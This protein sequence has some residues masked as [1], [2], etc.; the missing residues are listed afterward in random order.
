MSELE[1]A[2]SPQQAAETLLYTR[3]PLQLLAPQW[4]MMVARGMC[5]AFKS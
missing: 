4:Q 1:Q 5:V 2:Q 3:R